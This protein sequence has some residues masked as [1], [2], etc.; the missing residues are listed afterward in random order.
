MVVHIHFDH[1]EFHF[2]SLLQ[3]KE[4]DSYLEMDNE[5]KLPKRQLQV[6]KHHISIEHF[7]HIQLFQ[8]RSQETYNELFQSKPQSFNQKKKKNK[9]VVL[10]LLDNVFVELMLTLQNPK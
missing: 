7:L 3:K 1:L 10:D 2:I 5:I 8:L 4:K 6:H 9:L